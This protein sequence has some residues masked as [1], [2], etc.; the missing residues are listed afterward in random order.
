MLSLIASD[1]EVV[2]HTG[3]FLRCLRL[4]PSYRVYSMLS[5]VEV[6]GRPSLE[7]VDV[8]LPSHLNH[9][10]GLLAIDL[11]KDFA[12][13]EPH[14]IS[15]MMMKLVHIKGKVREHLI[16]ELVEVFILLGILTVDFP[17]DIAEDHEHA[18]F[19]EH[20][21]NFLIDLLA[22]KEVE[23]LADSDKIVFLVIADGCNAILFENNLAV[24]MPFYELINLCLGYAKHLGADVNSFGVWE[25]VAE[26][27]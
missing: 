19:I 22:G 10:V 15:I 18:S 4:Q 23:S 3:H 1:S 17:Q 9:Q 5:D 16:V 24:R 21:L 26:T 7:V 13:G 25:E 6:V 27:E 20:V 8:L 12:E 14:F 11:L 2:K